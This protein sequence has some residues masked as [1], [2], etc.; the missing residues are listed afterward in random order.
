M[1]KLFM[2]NLPNTVPTCLLFKCHF[3][4]LKFETSEI[5]T[6]TGGN[7]LNSNIINNGTQ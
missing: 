5:T 7:Y 2:I 4:A 6:I 1:C 3:L